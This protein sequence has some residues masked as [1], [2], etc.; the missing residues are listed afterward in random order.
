[1]CRRLFNFLAAC[2][3][4]RVP[5]N[6]AACMIFLYTVP[7]HRVQDF[8]ESIESVQA[9]ECI[10]YQ[11]VSAY[12]QQS[13]LKDPVRPQKHC[14]NLGHWSFFV[15]Q[16]P[17][18]SPAPIQVLHSGFP[19]SASCMAPTR[20]HLCLIAVTQ[21]FRRIVRVKSSSGARSQNISPPAL[22]RNRGP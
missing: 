8:V 19:T 18:L 22:S 15:S 14:P 9:R 2:C 11:H 10:G 4:V 13:C 5:I 6:P 3:A 17:V 20:I 21:P 7:L 16:H 1:M 12:Y